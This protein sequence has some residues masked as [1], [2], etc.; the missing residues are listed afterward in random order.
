MKKNNINL[1]ITICIDTEGPLTETLKATFQRLKNSK[2]IKLKPTFQNLK[3]LQ[4]KKINLNGREKEIADFVDPKRIKYLSNWSQVKNMVKK[5]TSK[6]FRSIFSDTNKR[7]LVYNWFIIDT[8]GYKNN[9]RKKSIGFHSILKNYE[10]ILSNTSKD[11]MGWHFHTV[12]ANKNATEYNT[13]WTNNDWHEQSLCRR[14][15][16]KDIFHSVFRAGGLIERNDLSFWLENFIPFDF[17]NKS[18]DPKISKVD[19][20]GKIDDW[21]RAPY[22]W[23]S[24]NPNF[25]DYRVKGTMKRTIFR[26]LDIDSNSNIISEK[27]VEKAFKRSRKKKT[28]L[29]VSCHDRRDLEPEI[30]HF[31]NLVKKVSLKYKDVNWSNENILNA[32]RNVLNLKKKKK[33]FIMIKKNKN[34]LNIKTNS[35]IFGPIPF[36]AI[37]ESNNLYYR[38][39]PTI[40]GKNEWCYKIPVEKKIK[41]VGVAACDDY[42][43][44]AKKIIKI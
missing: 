43:N 6:K 7:P 30:R 20:P 22:D 15:I 11:E 21:R 8:V 14:L 4:E 25:Y 34:I 44:I 27:E 31:M 19:T 9:P 2:N 41:F 32:P 3:K 12:P 23:S 5:I 28:I 39:N 18:K 38:D 17:S 10:K 24:Y 36:L 42:G 37:K 26:T 35:K 1:Y 29:S 33:L 16:D 13:C 40:E